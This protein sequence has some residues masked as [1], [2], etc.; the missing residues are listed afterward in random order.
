M[1]KILAIALAMVVVLGSMV[2]ASAEVDATV[3][4]AT[5]TQNVKAGDT[6]RVPVNISAYYD[7]YA[8]IVIGSPTYD[9][10]KLEFVGY[11]ESEKDFT[12]S[13][14]MKTSGEDFG[15]ITLPS[16][17]A[18]AIALSGGEIC[19]LVFNAKSN[20]TEDTEISIEVKEL[21]GYTRTANDT[22]WVNFKDLTSEVVPG[23]ILPAASADATVTVGTV[24]GPFAAGDEVAI[25]VNITEWAN[26]YAT[27]ELTFSY[28]E[29][30]LTLDAVE[31]SET[32]F[33]GAMAATSGKKFSLICNP[34]SDRQAEKLLGG[35]ICVAYFYAA[36]DNLDAAT[37][38][39]SATVKGY[40]NGSGDNWVAKHD[41]LTNVIAGGVG[42]GGADICVHA[43]GTATCISKAVCTLCGEEY[44]EVNA[45]NHVNTETRNETEIWCKD[46][47]TK[48]SGGEPI[49]GDA[50][51]TV[52]TLTGPFAAGD[53][54]AIP[55]SISTW[56]KAYASIELIFSYDEALLDLDFIE[57]SEFSGA[58][59]ATSGKKFSI[60]CNPS[61]DKSAEKVS[62]GEIC[63]AYFYANTNITSST[64]VTV[65][66]NVKGYSYGA[67]DGWVAFQE[68]DTAIVSGGVKVGGGDVVETFDATA[69]VGTL[70]K[71]FAQGEEVRIPVVVSKYENGYG[72]IDIKDLVYDNTV[73][74]FVE[75]V[76]SSTDFQISGKMAISNG[77]K[78]S[79]ILAPTSDAERAEIK[80]GEAGVLVFK[81]KKDI[82]FTTS[83]SATVTASGYTSAT[84][85]DVAPLKVQVT[86]GGVKGHEHAAAP[87]AEIKYD[88]NNH[89]YECGTVGCGNIIDKAPHE[90]G[91][92]TCCA[93]AVCSVCG[94]EYGT[95]DANNHKNTETINAKTADCGN[96]GYTGDTFC[97]DCQ[98]VVAT[99][100]VIPATGNHAGGEATC[101]AKAVCS[102]CGQE[103]GNF[104]SS[105]HDGG[106]EVRGYVAADCGN[107]GY[108]GDTYC[109]GCDAKIA[110]GETIP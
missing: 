81:A 29:A 59:G 88:E 28:D 38:T 100:S 69:T 36:V 11:E 14:V 6:V 95:V 107:D 104:N 43:G 12:G 2:F 24:K 67:E 8:T 108:T 47:N 99:G 85:I 46:C 83:V 39:V 21:R 30:L 48:I 52:G 15:I 41:L 32:G 5:I 73:L 27:I 57:Q 44:G 91:E 97:N 1:K 72:T 66:A 86:A 102:V 40:T 62:G 54:I 20:L 35:E 7:A 17:S 109:L 101:C 10:S 65:T 71:N 98:K 4:V 13:A 18:E 9:S 105:V 78:Y 76:E 70:E 93:K 106:T 79:L 90:G 42:E 33:S 26:A 82:T 58:M 103:Y 74:E 16:T 56:E 60:L 92:A 50:V 53:E 25:P 75:I 23:A 87:D 77:E 37:V 96:D 3:T 51:I 19:L 84:S 89:W 64:E 61:S 22:T 94:V 31:A 55:V 63:V 80:E 110:D 34:S 68:L 45:N 49:E